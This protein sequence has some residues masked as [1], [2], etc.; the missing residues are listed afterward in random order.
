MDF[1]PIAEHRNWCPW[2][3]L[4]PDLTSPSKSVGRE[5]DKGS[6]Q[7]STSGTSVQRAGQSDTTGHPGWLQVVQILAPRLLNA[8]NISLAKSLKQVGER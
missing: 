7:E 1:D 2:I 5:E 3:A 8:S 6:V 4:T